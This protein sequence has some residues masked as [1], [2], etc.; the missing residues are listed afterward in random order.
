MP[1]TMRAYRSRST[2]AMG[3][4]LPGAG[5]A[6]RACIAWTSICVRYASDWAARALAW[7]MRPGA[8]WTIF[9]MSP[10]CLNI[11]MICSF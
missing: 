4:R 11:F 7:S 2:P 8:A 3:S 6:V 9:A 5:C 1:F 10:N